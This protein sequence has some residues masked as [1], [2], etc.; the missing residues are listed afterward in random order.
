MR[1]LE[2]EPILD[3]LAGAR[4]K[5]IEYIAALSDEQLDITIP[6]APWADGTIGGVLGANGGHEM[7]HLAWVD[8]AVGAP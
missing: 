3:L 6:G 1:D 7:M 4:A 5:T 2:L 8:D